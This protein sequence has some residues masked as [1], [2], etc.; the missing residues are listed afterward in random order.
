V[1]IKQRDL[2]AILARDDLMGNKGF[3]GAEFHSL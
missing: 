1:E 3:A 2:C